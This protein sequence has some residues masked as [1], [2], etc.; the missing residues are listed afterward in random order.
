M[1]ERK[2]QFRVEASYKGEIKLKKEVMR[3]A[4]LVYGCIGYTLDKI[5]LEATIK[6]AKDIDNLI[7][8]L[9]NSKICL[10]EE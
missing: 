7:E 1:S 3:S 4:N 8:F 10:L 5:Q 2:K 6:T 9:T